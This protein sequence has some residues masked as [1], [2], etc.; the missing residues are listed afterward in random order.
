MDGIFSCNDVGDSGAGRGGF[1][2][3]GLFR[4]GRHRC[5]GEGED[6]R[7][8]VAV[9]VVVVDVKLVS[10]VFRGGSLISVDILAFCVDY[11]LDPALPRG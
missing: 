11:S 7:C 5:S 8:P 6:W 3:V 4:F 1:L 10:P 9:E 2:G